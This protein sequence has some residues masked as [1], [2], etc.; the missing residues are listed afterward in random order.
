MADMD[1]SDSDSSSFE[2]DSSEVTGILSKYQQE[3]KRAQDSF[4]FCRGT[5]ILETWTICKILFLAFHLTTRDV[6]EYFVEVGFIDVQYAKCPKCSQ[7]MLVQTEVSKV[8]GCIWACNN[9]VIKE[10]KIYMTEPCKTRVSVRKNSWFSRSKLSLL[11][12]LLFTYCWYENVPMEFVRTNFKFSSHTIVN[13]ASFCR[14][15]AID[16]VIVHSE[17]IG[18]PGLIVEIDE[19][20]FGKRK[21]FTI[22]HYT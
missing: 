18:G 11:E 6:Y 13:W 3:L 22:F 9:R 4:S 7:K 10:G 21:R 15:V 12:V 8:D 17:P 2:S 1:C 5:S 19:S 14:E 20:K 16:E